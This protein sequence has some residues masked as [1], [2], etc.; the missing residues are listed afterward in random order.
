MHISSDWNELVPSNKRFE[1]PNWN[2]RR[3]NNLN[4]THIVIHVTGTDSFN[5]V[6]NTFLRDNSVSAHYL[7]EKNGDLSQ[8][9]PDKYRAYHAGVDKNTRALYGKKTAIWKRYIKYFNWYKIYPKDAIYLDGDLK[10]V[11]DKT[12][13][14]FV[15]RADGQDWPNYD[16]FNTRWSN[17]DVP[18]NFAVDADP[19]NYSIGIETLGFGATKHDPNI[20]PA[21]MYDT[22]CLLVQN[23]S[24]KYDIPMVKGRV[25]G[26][27]DVNPVGR[28]GWD[29]GQ[30]F[31]WKK[32]FV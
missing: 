21:A 18:I 16:Y 10:P 29:P 31:N 30:G 4:P 3:L 20:Y 24:I 23:L 25:V 8:F 32:V 17:V 28:F 13:A 22:L 15:G 12:E 7:V 26:H 19:N 2:A 6:K 14:V 9:V 27:E 11:W 1:S 5:S